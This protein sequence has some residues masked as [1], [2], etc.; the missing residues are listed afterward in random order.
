MGIDISARA[1]ALGV[2]VE[3]RSFETSGLLSLPQRIAVIAQGATASSYS[4]ERRR[5][6]SAQ[7]AGQLYGFGSPIHLAVRELLPQNG[8]GV[9]SV[10]VTVYPL[11]DA[12]DGVA[13]TGSIVPVP[14]QS[15][16][17]EYRVVIA[18][19]Q[20]GPVVITD[21]DNAASVVTKM[22]TAING[23]LAMP[24]IAVANA[25]T[26]ELTAKWAGTTG[27]DI[28]L[29][30]TGGDGGTTFA[31]TNMSGGLA[32]PTVDASLAQFGGTWE[33]LVLNGLGTGDT[34]ALN[35]IRDFGEGRWGALEHKPFVAFAGNV[36]ATVVG[37]IAVPDARKTDRV[38]AQL[39]A[40]GSM[41]LPIVVAARQLARIASMA[42]NNPPTDYGS[43]VATG[44]IPGGVEWNYPERDQAVKA[45]SSTSV[46][47]NDEVVIGDVVTF[48]HPDGE[49][50]PAY[51]YVV[52]IIKIQNLIY[53]VDSRFRGKPWDGAPLI[54]DDQPTVNP[55]A[56]RPKDAKAQ[57]FAIADA[58]ALAALISD[59]DYTKRNTQAVI[60]S[61]NAKRLDIAMP[62]KLSG[63]ANIIDTTV[64]FTFYYGALAAA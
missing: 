55:N 39:V 59:A 30:V 21:A 7:E 49:E 38:N 26:L 9:G 14:N 40:P 2:S 31:I 32:N 16:S 33:T 42:N 18:G 24:V 5:V 54:P 17:A 62:V 57:I 15:A 47:R 4:T 35:A 19:I 22:A 56:R 1:R 46:I 29:Q 34:A 44:L 48:Y 41:Q 58:A 6:N 20:S 43:L 60:S 3:N 64:F 10:P 61:T 63:N 45:G 37:A 52:D 36:D 53:N 11:E 25:G 8:D 12:Y 50:D 13:A 27:D 28:T 51:R 23:V